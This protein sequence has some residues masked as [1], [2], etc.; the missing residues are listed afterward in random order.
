MSKQ[1]VNIAFANSTVQ[2]HYT[3]ANGNL[4]S[5]NLPVP[6]ANI[7]IDPSV[8][9]ASTSFDAVNNVWNTTLPWDIDD[10]AFLSG[11]PWLVPAG[12]TPADIEPVTWSG[13][14]AVERDG[15]AHRLAVGRRRVLLVRQRRH[16]T[17]R[18]TDGYGLRQFGFESRPHWH[19]EKLQTVCDSGRP[20]QGRQELHGVLQQERGHRMSP[21]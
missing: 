20:R 3:D 4:V 5:M 17:R 7:V 2:F 6:N 19:T 13:T 15:S 1:K 9:V 8:S 21:H 16:H 12:G 11:M 10:N 14:F 18:E